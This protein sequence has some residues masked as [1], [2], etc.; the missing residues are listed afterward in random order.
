LHLALG[1]VDWAVQAAIIALYQLACETPEPRDEIEQL[2]YFLKGCA[3]GRGFTCY[4]PA[5]AILWLHLGPRRIEADALRAWG[6]EAWFG[7][8]DEV[9]GHGGLDLIGYAEHISGGAEPIAEW[10][11]RLEQDPSLRHAMHIQL[12]RAELRAQLRQL[13]PA[14]DQAMGLLRSFA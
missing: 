9:E 8:T 5:L 6:N 10:E 13:D 4:A 11:A 3:A 12:G 7:G 1:P 14:S 2:F